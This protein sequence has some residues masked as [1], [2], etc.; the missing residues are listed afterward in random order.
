MI[1]QAFILAIQAT[2]WSTYFWK[3]SKL[4]LFIQYICSGVKIINLYNLALA[5]DAQENNVKISMLK[6]AYLHMQTLNLLLIIDEVFK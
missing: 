2:Y 5:S 1:K 3:D 4:Q 6:D